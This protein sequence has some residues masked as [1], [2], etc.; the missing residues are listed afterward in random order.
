MPDVPQDRKASCV[1]GCNYR[2]AAFPRYLA[3]FCPE[4]GTRS[5]I[6]MGIKGSAMSG[7]SRSVR[8]AVPTIRD[9]PVKTPAI[10][11]LSMSR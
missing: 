7:P 5:E 1:Q 6:A 2:G 8:P 10:W 4:Q 9:P 11:P 3:R